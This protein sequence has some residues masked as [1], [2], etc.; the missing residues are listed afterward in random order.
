MA[1]IFH[2][3][4]IYKNTPEVFLAISSG[5]EISKWWTKWSTGKAIVGEVFDLYFSQ[6]YHWKAELIDVKENVKCQWKLIKA[7]KDWLHT[8]FGFNLIQRDQLTLAEFYHLGW[9]EKN[10][11]FKRSNYCWAM[12]LQ[13]LKQ[14]IETTEVVPFEDRTFV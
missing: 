5:D 1:D 3:V 9:P 10:E 4:Y 13:L 2:N 14:Y 7:D 12:Y 6:D 11:H 8:I